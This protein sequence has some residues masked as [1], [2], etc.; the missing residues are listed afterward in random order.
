MRKLFVI[1]VVSMLLMSSLASAVLAEPHPADEYIPMPVDPDPG[2][3]FEDWWI[4]LNPDDGGHGWELPPG[5]DE[6][7]G[8][9]DPEWDG[10]TESEVFRGLK[11][12]FTFKYFQGP[13][14]G[15]PTYDYSVEPAEVTGW[16]TALTNDGY[17]T[18]WVGTNGYIV[19]G[20]VCL[21]EQGEYRGECRD[22]LTHDEIGSLELEPWG[23][24]F[25]G[26]PSPER[27]DNLIMPFGTDLVI[28]DNSFFEVDSVAFVCEAE[29]DECGDCEPGDD[30][31]KCD[32]AET[33]FVSGPGGCVCEKDGCW[34]D[35]CVVGCLGD[36]QCEAECEDNQPRVDLQG[37]WVPCD[38]HEVVRPRG[39]LLY[40]T[41]GEE[42]NR[43]FVAEWA[44][45]KVY[46]TGGLATFQVQ[47]WEGNNA[48][49]FLYKD[50]KPMAFF[51]DPPHEAAFVLK[52]VLFVGIEDFYG[53]TGVGQAYTGHRTASPEGWALF[54]P[55]DEMSAL[56]YAPDA[57]TGVRPFV[58]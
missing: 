54:N 48:V 10:W 26:I 58:P 19:F 20:V 30:T 45:A 24:I 44:N 13:A 22:F 42:P 31:V 46:E 17:D 5:D 4:E 6:I 28:G 12:G 16:K 53:T 49:L 23:P 39:R 51:E 8:D 15:Q 14:K 36:A 29:D 3:A 2:Y 35:D 57:Y 41:V 52:D 21:N 55:L 34:L 7:Y 40:K 1:L 38:T 11:M 27:P 47:L 43:K 37:Y 32:G 9:P 33:D 56:A 25:R 50:F 18:V